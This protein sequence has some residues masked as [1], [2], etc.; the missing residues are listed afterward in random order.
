M[1]AQEMRLGNWYDHH[2]TPKQVTVSVIEDV[3]E[4]ERIWVKP[5]K[6]TEE[7]LVRFGFEKVLN[8]YKKININTING[9][10]APFIVLYLDGF[11]YDDLRFRTKLIHVHQFQNLY[12]S[13][14]GEELTLTENESDVDSPFFIHCDFEEFEKAVTAKQEFNIVKPKDFMYGDYKVDFVP[15][16]FFDEKK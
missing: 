10:N 14:T 9:K 13:L 4:S 2:G 3:W 7:W 15:N 8:R 5:I 6:L 12:H 16:P 11:E 1:K